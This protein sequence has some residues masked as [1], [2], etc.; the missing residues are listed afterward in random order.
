MGGFTSQRSGVG[1]GLPNDGTEARHAGPTPLSN[2]ATQQIQAL[3]AMCA[4]M[5]H[6]KAIVAVVLLDVVLAGVAVTA[7]H[8]DGQTIGLEAPLRWP[9]LGHWRQDVQQQ[10]G[11][12][13][14]LLQICAV[15]DVNQLGAIQQ[16]RQSAL[17]VL[18]S[19]SD[20]S[21]KYEEGRFQA[22]QAQ[23][24]QLRRPRDKDSQGEILHPPR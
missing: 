18:A 13:A 23:G 24:R 14:L 20:A 1:H 4:F 10:F 6:V 17:L 9:A 16:E 7:V 5:N 11:I 21:G 3:D 2:F 15:L 12:R 22:L 8:L 19:A